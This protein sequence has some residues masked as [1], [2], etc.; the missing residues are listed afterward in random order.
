MQRIFFDCRHNELFERK[1][2]YFYQNS[3]KNEKTYS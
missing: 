3:K 2:S 1:L